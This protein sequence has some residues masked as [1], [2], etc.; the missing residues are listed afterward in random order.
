MFYKNDAEIELLFK[1]FENRTISKTDWTHAAHLTVG[2]YYCFHYPFGTAK[3]LMSDGIYWLNDA[4]GT[5]NTET[6]GYHETLTV[7]WLK[8][9]AA[10]LEENREEKSLAVLANDL[11]AVCKNTKLPLKYYSRELLFST[12][13]RLNYV[14]P[15]LEK[16]PF[17]MNGLIFA[18]HNLF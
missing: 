2:L 7:F 15:D 16:F 1:A 5:P 18:L 3:N 11:L 17:P 10:F 14:E 6:S 13:A 9:I 12:E 8:T 4:H